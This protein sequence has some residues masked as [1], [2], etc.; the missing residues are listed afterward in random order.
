MPPRL[1]R[2]RE[3]RW[4]HARRRLQRLS[5]LL[6]GYWTMCVENILTMAAGIIQEMDIFWLSYGF[7]LG[8]EAKLILS[9]T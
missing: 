2:A 5:R 9:F 6:S 7:L 3:N 8:G 4:H 1:L